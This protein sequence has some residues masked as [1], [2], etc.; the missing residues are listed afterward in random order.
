[1]LHLRGSLIDTLC[2]NGAML[3][4]HASKEVVDKVSTKR[5]ICEY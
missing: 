5:S 4:V 2:S 3:A 1:M